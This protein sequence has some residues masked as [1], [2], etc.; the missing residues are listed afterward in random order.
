MASTAAPVGSDPAEGID[1]D[2]DDDHDDDF[3]VESDDGGDAGG[4]AEAKSVDGTYGPAAKARWL[5]SF[6]DASWTTDPTADVRYP[7]ALDAPAAQELVRDA[8]QSMYDVYL[9]VTPKALQR[10]GK[11]FRLLFDKKYG[12]AKGGST[13]VM[14]KLRG[15]SQ[16][17]YRF[18]KQVRPTTNA[19]HLRA[20]L[21]K[22]APELLLAV[23]AEQTA[24]GSI[25]SSDGADGADGADDNDDDGGDDGGDDAV[26]SYV[27]MVTTAL[28]KL[29]ENCRSTK[30]AG[31]KAKAAGA[32][33]ASKRPVGS[34]KAKAS[35]GTP[36]AGGAPP[37]TDDA[38]KAAAPGAGSSSSAPGVSDRSVEPSCVGLR[39]YTAVVQLQARYASQNLS[40]Q[41]QETVQQAAKLLAPLEQEVQQASAQKLS[42]QE[43]PPAAHWLASRLQTRDGRAA[44]SQLLAASKALQP[45]S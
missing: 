35:D 41:D 5:S 27:S 36:P 25:G 31:G 2:F 17:K 20:S 19:A 4:D 38:K 44:L 32:P 40:P 1:D 24:G 10:K 3:V 22:L 9:S 34:G 8:G 11:S 39:E 43:L 15:G 37:P 14:A 42:K 21:E 45:S 18:K 26:A 29:R 30:P 12:G 6:L 13:N 7:T 16:T 28:R 23:A 33:A